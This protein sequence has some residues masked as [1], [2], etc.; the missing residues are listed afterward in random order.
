MTPRWLVPASVLGGAVLLAYRDERARQTAV[1]W[2]GGEDFPLA[3]IASRVALERKNGRSDVTSTWRGDLYLPVTTLGDAQRAEDYWASVLRRADVKM[4]PDL[5]EDGGRGPRER[6]FRARMAAAKELQGGPFAAERAWLAIPE[7]GANLVPGALR[8]FWDA[9]ARA[10]IAAQ[11]SLTWT[12]PR[13]EEDYW[14]AFGY[15]AGETFGQ[16]GEWL[17]KTGAQAGAFA[18]GVTGGFVSGILQ[19]PLVLGAVGIAIALYY[20]GGSAA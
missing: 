5:A 7:G 15:A 12:G 11:A 1:L 14:A 9:C 2:T 19:H 6:D 3:E 8:A 4:D 17:G 16:I 18:A 13:D 20:R 10:A